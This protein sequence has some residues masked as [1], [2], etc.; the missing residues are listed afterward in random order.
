MINSY[1]P[2]LSDMDTCIVGVEAF[3]IQLINCH[4]PGISLRTRL[5]DGALLKYIPPRFV[6]GNIGSVEIIAKLVLCQLNIGDG[7]SCSRD[8]VHKIAIC[9][10]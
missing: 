9:G 1:T 4:H 10:I 5:T 3:F 7:I 6:G 8:K 2:I